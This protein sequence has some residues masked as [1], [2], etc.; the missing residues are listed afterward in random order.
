MIQT[1]YG[2][3][4]NNRTEPIKHTP[5][6]VREYFVKYEGLSYWHCDWAPEVVVETFHKILHRI[7]TNRNDMVNP[8]SSES[9][10]NQEDDDG[11]QPTKTDDENSKYY[12]PELVDLY[13]NGIKP[14][15]LQIHR[16]LNYKKTKRGD[17]W[18]LIKWRDLGYEQST[19]ELEDGEV[20]QKIRD[21]KKQVDFYWSHKKLIQD[22]EEREAQQARRSS[23]KGKKGS[24][25]DSHI[26][27]LDEC[28]ID[29]AQRYEKQ[30]DYLD[31][32]GGRL[33]PYQLEGLNWLRF[34]WSQGTDVILA[35]EMGL[36]KTVQSST[37]LYSLFK[38]N[39]TKG[40]FLVAAPLSTIV[41]WE[42]EFEFWAPDMYVVTYLG[43]KESR[44]VIREHEFSYDD[45]AIR[46][47]PKASKMRQGHKCKFNVLLTS[48]E[49]IC[50]DSA[51]LGSIDWHCLVIDEA[52]RLKSNQSK[53]FR[54]LFDYSIKFKVLLTG[55]PLQNN[56]EELFHLLNFLR[57][58]DFNDMAGFLSEFSDLS[59][60]D[61]VKKLHD[62]LGPHLLRRLK[63]DV[64]KSMP[65]KSELIVRIDM[66]PMQ[67][68]YYKLL[69][70]KNYDALQSKQGGHQSLL[71][72]VM[73]LKK[74]TFN[75]QFNIK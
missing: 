69:L 15:Y 39:H 40:P 33:H 61:Q 18:Y 24:K 47:G 53:F 34:S 2:L 1:T 9:L 71:N 38:E 8:P 31:L 65:S 5:Q 6:R 74:V 41:N 70:T 62:L 73:Q 29:P 21:W 16:V 48:Y 72:I 12:D 14:S 45:N 11:S 60:D 49:M 52:H 54:I 37:F 3:D 28:K 10:K 58:Q 68:K 43:P 26:D 57:P 51:T 32:T 75:C 17:E 13:R 25:R 22:M 56:L 19:W 66:S 4:P 42:R 30:P 7:Y 67:K 63:A 50:L 23:S 44:A 35:D 20:A 55:T 27:P 64:L 46:S 36:G 59:K